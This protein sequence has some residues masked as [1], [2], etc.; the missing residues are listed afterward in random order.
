MRGLVTVIA[1]ALS[2]AAAFA[3]THVVRLDENVY[4]VRVVKE[5]GAVPSS[6]FDRYGFLKKDWPLDK[7]V[8]ALPHAFEATTD[9]QETRIVFPLTAGE[10]LYGLGDVDRSSIDRRGKAYELWITNLKSYIPIGFLFSSEGWGVFVNSTRRIRVDAGKTDGDRLVI[11]VPDAAADFYFFS[12]GNLRGLFNDYTRLTGRPMMMPAYAFGWLFCCNEET[13]QNSLVADAIRFRDKDF[14]CDTLSLE[15]SWINGRYDPSTRKFW[16]RA[17]FDFPNWSPA[18]DHTW[19]GA[20]NRLGFKLSLWLCTDYDVTK[21]EEQCLVD[22]ARRTSFGKR[23]VRAKSGFLDDPNLNEPEFTAANDKDARYMAMVA[24]TLPFRERKVP[25]GESP[26]F[27]HLKKFIDQGARA[28]KTDFWGI[29][30][31]HPKRKWANGMGDDEAHNLSSVVYARQMKEGYEGYTDERSM[32]Y[33][34]PGFSCI[35]AYAPTWA[36]DTGGGSDAC[37][38]V[39]NHAL[40]GHSNHS[41]DLDPWR[42]DS[43]HFLFLCPWA[44]NNN[45][46]RWYQPWLLEKDAQ[47]AIR[48]Y[49]HLRYRLFPYLYAAG[50]EAHRTGWPMA[51]PLPLVYPKFEPLANCTNAYMLGD[52]LLVGAYAD[53]LTLPPGVWHEWRTDRAET[54]PKTVA[55]GRTPTWGGALYVKAGAII[56]TTPGLQ[57]IDCGWHEKVVVEVWPDAEGKGVLYEDEGNSVAC[58]RGE[59]CETFFALEKKGGK[60]VFAVSPRKGS[61]VPPKPLVLSLRVHDAPGKVR[62]IDLGPVTADRRVEL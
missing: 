17:K 5:G 28:F 16:N 58:E 45:W 14:P 15:P 39:L 43:Q 8:D 59:F 61:F 36:G 56:P 20:I 49:L 52:S 11:A 55:V 29:G 10:H 25:E 47:S 48:D 22:P 38:S 44:K 46:S 6:G 23:G 30:F 50:A 40:S 35:Q 2:A 19:V 54:G 53:T 12:A 60:T 62:T 32:A 3:E 37:L 18:G 26:W 21:F 33:Q 1:V 4:R 42:V 34:S 41:F 13:D 7:S 31:D 57:H 51:R 9:G 24:K 27:E